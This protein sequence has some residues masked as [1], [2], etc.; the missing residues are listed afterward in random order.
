LIINKYLRICNSFFKYYFYFFKN[1]RS[2]KNSKN[3]SQEGEDLFLIEFFKNKSEGFYVDVGAFHPFRINNTY[4]LYKKGFRGINI[5]ISATSIDFFNLA[6][7]DD[8]NLNIGASNKF[9]NKIFF[10]KKNLS[11]HNT[12]SKSLAESKIQNEP[13]KKK[14]YIE[15]KPLTQIIDDTKFSNK[16]IDFLNIDAEG[17]DYEVLQ[18][19]DL[20]KYSP[21]IICIEISPL[22]EK[23]NKNYKDTKI[24]KYLLKNNY[25][26]TWKGYNSFIFELNK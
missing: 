10:S 7:S 25:K 20:K 24:F 9:E 1:F 8:I 22:I 16:K 13:F 17:H 12:F 6:R 3:F 11:F 23:K 18:G 21:K 2:I 19:L 14:Y 26:L 4:A 15:C 5:D